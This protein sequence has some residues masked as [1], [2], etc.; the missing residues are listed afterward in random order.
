[1]LM[2]QSQTTMIPD[3]TKQ[4]PY[5]MIQI[6]N[7]GN[8]DTRGQGL[9]FSSVCV[10]SHPVEDLRLCAARSSVTAELSALLLGSLMPPGQGSQGPPLVSSSQ[11]STV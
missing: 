7:M 2:N 11:S 8:D 5:E 9:C 1:M 4:L 6:W 3:D 10:D